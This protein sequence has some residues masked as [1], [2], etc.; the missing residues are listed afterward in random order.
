MSWRLNR[1]AGFGSEEVPAR[2]GSDIGYTK[3]WHDMQRTPAWHSIMISGS[4]RLLLEIWLRHNGRNNGQIPYSVREAVQYFE[5]SPKK[6]VRWFSELQE[7]GFVVATKRGSFQQKTGAFAARATT[8][9]LTMEPCK[10]EK[11]TW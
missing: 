7:L 5:C 3:P 1:R 4:V 9:Q 2:R 11:P 10:G 6:A 8:W